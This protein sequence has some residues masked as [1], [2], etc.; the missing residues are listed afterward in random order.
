MRAQQGTEREL[1][2]KT[3]SGKSRPNE[4]VDIRVHHHCSRCGLTQQVAARSRSSHKWRIS[5]RSDGQC[6]DNSPAFP[7]LVCPRLEIF[8]ATSSRFSSLPQRHS[9]R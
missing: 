4:D 1:T 7:K 9:I 2:E 6:A 5:I 8:S 3:S